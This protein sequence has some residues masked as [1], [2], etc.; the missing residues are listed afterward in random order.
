MTASLVLNNHLRFQG[1]A[2]YAMIGITSGAVLNI[3]LDPLFIFSFKMGIRGAAIA[4]IISQFVGFCVLL[5]G[6]TKGGNIRIRVKNFRPTRLLWGEILKGG[7]PSLMRQAL[8]GIS[9]V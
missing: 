6:T 9:T 8:T 2:F 5:A 1:N 7:T 3:G 4:T